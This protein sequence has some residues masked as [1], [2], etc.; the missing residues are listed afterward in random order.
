MLKSVGIKPEEAVN[1]VA[2]VKAVID[3]NSKMN[4]SQPILPP[5]TNT[6]PDEEIYDL[7]DLLSKEDP[8]KLYI[9][10]KKIGEG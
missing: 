7:E 5:Q 1:N 2:T 6:L 4:S 10:Q 3:F 8:N 9:N